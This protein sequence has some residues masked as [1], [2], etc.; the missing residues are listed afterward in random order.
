MMR[1]TIC[2]KRL[3]QRHYLHLDLALPTLTNMPKYLHN[4]LAGCSLTFADQQRLEYISR[5]LQF[6]PS[7]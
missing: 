2:V 7:M 5:A 6:G 1:T 4:Q 3:G